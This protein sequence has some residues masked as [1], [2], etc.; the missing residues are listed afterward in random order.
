MV[1][2]KNKIMVLRETAYQSFGKSEFDIYILNK[3]NI[4]STDFVVR[5]TENLM[6]ALSKI[7]EI[8]FAELEKEEGFSPILFNKETSSLQEITNAMPLVSTDEPEF[9]FRAE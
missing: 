1:K 8:S 3:E 7:K 5:T 4:L 9:V 6:F 2:F